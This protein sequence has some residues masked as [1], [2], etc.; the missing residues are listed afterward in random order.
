MSPAPPELTDPPSHRKESPAQYRS[1]CARW[2]A[3]ARQEPCVDL[4]SVEDTEVAEYRAWAG[5]RAAH[6]RTVEQLCDL[7]LHRLS[8][9]GAQATPPVPADPRIAVDGSGT[10]ARAA[11]ACGD[12]GADLG[13]SGNGDKDFDPEAVALSLGL[14]LADERFAE[15]EQDTSAPVPARIRVFT[16]QSVI[17]D[18]P[19]RDEMLRRLLL[20]L[21]AGTGSEPALLGPLLPTALPRVLDGSITVE[22]QAAHTDQG[23]AAELMDRADR[24]AYA[25]ARGT[26]DHDDLPLRAPSRLVTKKASSQPLRQETA[27][28]PARMATTKIRT[29]IIGVSMRH[30]VALADAPVVIGLR[31][32]AGRWIAVPKVGTR[33]MPY[34]SRRSLD[35]DSVLPLHEQALAGALHVWANLVEEGFDPQCTL[36]VLTQGPLMP[37]SFRWRAAAPKAW[38]LLQEQGRELPLVRLTPEQVSDSG[39]DDLARE[40]TRQLDIASAPRDE[41]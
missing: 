31:W 30:D 19:D 2:R 39:L 25:I 27:V 32:Y 29:T 38:G 36:V 23:P 15:L 26:V 9:E 5:T 24:L 18:A 41:N 14:R 1:R 17:T 37:V 35:T 10:L 12:W 28:Q 16:D 11:V 33:V 21:A 7:A 40:V 20:R 4:W 34:R 8:D 3:W 13:L 6:D 22:R